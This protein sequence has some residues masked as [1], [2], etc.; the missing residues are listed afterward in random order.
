[1]PVLTDPQRLELLKLLQ[2]QPQ[3]SQRDLAQ[4]LGVS[5]GKANYCLKALMEK[6]LVKFGNFRKN[7]DKRVYAYLLTPAG[8]EEKTRITVA[9]L[10]RKVAEYEALEQEIEQL[11]SD[12]EHRRIQ[13][14]ALPER[15][16]ENQ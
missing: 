8:L 2:D 6:G 9:F 4:A 14:D 16:T 10:K 1:M 12:L 15:Q 5:L 3:M 13:S 7:P 11:R